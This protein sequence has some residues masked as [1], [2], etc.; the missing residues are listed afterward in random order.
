MRTKYEASVRFCDRQLGRVLDLMDELDLWKDTMLIVNTD[1]GFFL[2]EHGYWGKGGSPN[3][4]EL[5]HT[6]LFIWDPRSGRK[7][8]TAPRWCRPLIWPPPCWITLASRSPPTC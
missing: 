4:E 5:V 3:Y 1:H 8:Y 2:S 6:P 7:A